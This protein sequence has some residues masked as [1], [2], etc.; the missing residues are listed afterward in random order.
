MGVG[1]RETSLFDYPQKALLERTNM[2]MRMAMIAV[3]GV[4]VGALATAASTL[5]QQTTKAPSVI[6]PHGYI[7]EEVRVGQ[8]CVV[9]VFRGGPPTDNIAAVPCTR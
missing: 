3:I 2:T 4:V 6:S 5:A 8:S 1:S 7:V 9:L